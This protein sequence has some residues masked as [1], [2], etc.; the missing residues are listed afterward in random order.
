MR[1]KDNENEMLLFIDGAAG[2]AMHKFNGD[3]ENPGEYIRRLMAGSSGFLPFLFLNEDERDDMLIIGPGGGTEVLFGLLADVKNITGVEVNKDLVDIVR[4]YRDYNG[5]IYSD[6]ENVDIVVD[7]G[8]SFLRDSDRKYDIIMSTL[9]VTKGSR[10]SEGYALTESYLFTVESI[11]DYLDHLT[12]EGRMIVVMHNWYETL[13]LAVT[14]LAA[15]EEMGVENQDAMKH[16]IY[17]WEEDESA[18][19]D[20]ED[21]IRS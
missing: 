17:A 7:E 12:D 13:R 6:F 15:F 11:K 3:R 8:R 14:A 9:P 1:Y 2:T 5:G 10:S 4:E 18:S 16:Y 21:A 19:G 20:Q